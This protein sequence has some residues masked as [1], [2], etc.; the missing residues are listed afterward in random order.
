MLGSCSSCHDGIIATGK[1][2]GHFVTQQECNVCHDSVAWIP[3]IY[4]HMGL[5]YEPLDHRD[6]LA[7]TDCH[8]NNTEAVNWRNAAFQPDC[9][10]CHANDFKSGPHKKFENPDV[11]YTVSELRDCS[12][13]CHVYTDATMTTIKK[14]RPGPEHRISDGGF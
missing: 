6:N 8:Q 4:R 12:G 13:A 10:G 3:H 2:P 1:D 9:A 14:N 11:K 7:C 5:P